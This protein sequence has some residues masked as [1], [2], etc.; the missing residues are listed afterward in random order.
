MLIVAIMSSFTRSDWSA[1]ALRNRSTVQP[2][3]S[4]SAPERRQ[5][6]I[7]TRNPHAATSMLLGSESWRDAG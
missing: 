2:A 6:E 1:I 5:R 3:S 4:I 7:Q